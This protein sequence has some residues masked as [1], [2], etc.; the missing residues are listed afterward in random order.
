MSS[1]D[2]GSIW[3]G[4]G[5]KVKVLDRNDPFN[6]VNGKMYRSGAVIYMYIHNNKI[7]HCKTL[8]GFYDTWQPG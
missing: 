7:G 3:H 1:P 2:I 8:E 4:Q 6:F 5:F